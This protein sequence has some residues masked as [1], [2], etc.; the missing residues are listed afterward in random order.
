MY[1]WLSVRIDMPIILN[2]DMAKNWHRNKAVA[3]EGNYMAMHKY[4]VMHILDSTWI[5]VP[6]FIEYL[7]TEGA[8]RSTKPV[9]LLN[10]T[11]SKG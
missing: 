1:T 2:L 4:Y 7:Q 5:C 11:R 10:S 8:V 3:Q 9:L 6:C